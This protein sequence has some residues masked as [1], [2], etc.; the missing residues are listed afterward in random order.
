M[1]ETCVAML[2]DCLQHSSDKCLKCVAMLG[3]C[4]Q[5]SSDKCLKCVAMLGDCLQ[6]SSDKCL[7]CRWQ[8][9]EMAC[10]TATSVLNICGQVF[11]I[12]VDKCLK[13]LW[14]CV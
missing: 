2:G 4:L 11:G 8:L 1:F 5:H 6:H 13:Y 3:D 9:R 14:T 10:G 12:V 7:K